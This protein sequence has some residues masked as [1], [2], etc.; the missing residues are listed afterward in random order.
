MNERTC[1][2]VLSTHI[3]SLSFLHLQTL[4]SSSSVSGP[5]AIFLQ[6]QEFSSSSCCVIQYTLSLREMSASGKCNLYFSRDHNVH[7]FLFC[8][9]SQ[10]L[11]SWGQFCVT[12]EGPRLVLGSL[13]PWGITFLLLLVNHTLPSSLSN[14]TSCSRKPLL[15]DTSLASFTWNQMD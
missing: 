4:A 8:I 13:S 11:S 5:P 7:F 12:L 2:S 10:K 6:Y 1:S 14:W 3:S 9:R 15:G